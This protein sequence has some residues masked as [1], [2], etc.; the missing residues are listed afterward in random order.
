[1]TV[2]LITGKGGRLHV[3][4]GD[5]GAIQAGVLGSGNYLLANADGSYPTV[6]MKDANHINVPVMNLVLAGRYARVT[7][8]ET[9][10]VASGE[11]GKNRNDILCLKYARDD[12]NVESLSFEVLQGTPS[13]STAADPTIP[14]GSVLNGDATVYF[15]IARIPITGITVG[16]PVA[17]FSTR[18]AL[19]DSVTLESQ[20]F[21]FC[22]N[23]LRLRKQHG[24]VIAAV[25]ASPTGTPAANLY[26]YAVNEKIVEGY[27]PSGKDAVMTAVSHTGD[28]ASILVHPDGTMNLFGTLVQGHHYLWLG[29]WFA[30]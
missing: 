24:L 8:A 26:N 17:L 15:P 2:N 5:M 29:V 18:N 16:T 1:M 22:G 6:T 9:V 14:A 13:T 30:E 25:S 28:V 10:Q 20:P 19:W 27:R 12:K 4:S 11:S 23:A 3:T 7:A 21:P